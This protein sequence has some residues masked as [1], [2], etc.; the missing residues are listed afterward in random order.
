[1]IDVRRDSQRRTVDMIPGDDFGR[2]LAAITD[3]QRGRR[4]QMNDVDLSREEGFDQLRPGT[5]KF[6]FLYVKAFFLIEFSGMRHQQ[7]RRI[8]DRQITDAQGMQG[9]ALVAQPCRPRYLAAASRR[10]RMAV[11]A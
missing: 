2:K 6:G 3:H 5:E 9:V 4:Q 7:G 8:G 10:A 11:N 1:M